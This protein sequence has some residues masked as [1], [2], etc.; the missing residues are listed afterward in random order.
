VS[1]RD[2][3]HRRARSRLAAVRSQVAPALRRAVMPFRAETP[4]S[5]QDRRVL[6]V[7]WGAAGMLFACVWTAALALLMPG[8]SGARAIIA[9]I[10]LVMGGG[11]FF[12]AAGYALVGISNAL[13]TSQPA[14]PHRPPPPRATHDR[15]NDRGSA[16]GHHAP[17]P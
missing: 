8:F 9:G 2:D 16:G 12:A 10:L 1:G 13:I 5:A 11:L 6:A 14:R 3:S 4:L 7:C 15:G 17:E